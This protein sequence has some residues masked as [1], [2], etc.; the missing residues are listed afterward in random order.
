MHG[1]TALC[2]SAPVLKNKFNVFFFNTLI[3]KICFK[4]MIKRNFRGDVT[5]IS[6]R[7]EPLLC[8]GCSVAGLAE[9]SVMSSRIFFLIIIE[10]H[11]YRIKVQL[12]L[13]KADTVKPE[14]P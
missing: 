10:K 4:I 13:I 8:I 12:P 11:I 14:F 9:I 3:Q 7:K 1:K 5:G 2:I 6:V